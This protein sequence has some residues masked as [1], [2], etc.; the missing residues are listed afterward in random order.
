MVTSSPTRSFVAEDVPA[1]VAMPVRAVLM[2]MVPVIVPVI[3]PVTVGM[4]HLVRSPPL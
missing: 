1:M 4:I 3:M 2:N